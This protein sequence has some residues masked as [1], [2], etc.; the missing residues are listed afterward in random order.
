MALFALIR[1]ATNGT[2]ATFERFQEMASAPTL[3]ANKPLKWLPANMPVIDGRWQRSRVDPAQLW[4]QTEIAFQVQSKTVADV[5]QDAKSTLKD[6]YYQ[7]IYEANMDNGEATH[8]SE[9]QAHRSAMIAMNDQTDIWDYLD[10]NVTDD[11]GWT[12]T[13]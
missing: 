7:R 3:S 2:D 4:A 13:Q 11:A 8:R 10:A 6:E 1:R 9:A 12:Y 5:K